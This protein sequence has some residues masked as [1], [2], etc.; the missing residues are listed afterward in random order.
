MSPH[1]AHLL[2]HRCSRI[3]RGEK[4]G[5]KEGREGREGDCSLIYPSPPFAEH[6]GVGKLEKGERKGTGEKERTHPFFI[7]SLL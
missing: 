1:L 3:G 6:A 4:K 2:P 7:Y 5:K